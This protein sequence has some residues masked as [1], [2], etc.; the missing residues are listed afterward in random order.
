[1]SAAL[2]LA[3]ARGDFSMRALG[4]R[5]RVDPMA[6]YRHFRDKD[7]VLDAMVDAA[8]A[9]LEADAAGSGAAAERLRRLCLGFHRAISAHPGVAQRVST[10]RPTLGP[11]TVALTEGCL[12][13]LRELGL[14]M[15]QATR[16]FLTLIR[17][18]TGVVAAEERVRFDGTSEEAWRE[19]LRAGYATVSP[20]DHPNVGA[21]SS[22]IADLRFQEDFEFGLDLLIDA[23]VRLGR[24]T[25][26]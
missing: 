9:D 25:A 13:M 20:A 26:R 22:E 24:E 8:L 7:A 11:H 5:L 4:Q 18:I 21:M 19:D 2:E 1:V 16:A 12:G 15:R 3:D 14:D 23:L 17:F 6:I 10:T